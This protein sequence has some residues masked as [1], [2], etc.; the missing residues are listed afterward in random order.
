MRHFSGGS[1]QW[2]CLATEDW[3]SDMFGGGCLPPQRR[4][5]VAAVLAASFAFIAC[6][7]P[8]GKQGLNQLMHC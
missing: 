5:D 3:V 1:G 8:P 2:Y 7:L 4:A 6:V